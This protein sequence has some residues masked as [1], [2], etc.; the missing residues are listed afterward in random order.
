MEAELSALA[1]AGGTA[2][3]QAVGTEAWT[4]M[5]DRVA[6]WFRREGGDEELTAMLLEMSRDDLLPDGHEAQFTAVWGETLRRLLAKNPA[7]AAELRR[8]VV[9]FAPTVSGS[10][11]VVTC[12]NGH[13]SDSA[14]WCDICGV[15]MGH[16]VAPPVPDT[17]SPVHNTVS[18]GAQSTVIQT[19]TIDSLT[20]N[21]PSAAPPGDHVN[22]S[23]GTFHA[24]V[25]GVQNNYGTPP[26]QASADGW[27]RIGELRRLAPGAHPTR[28]FGDEPD[29]PPY[30][31]RDSD[32][33]LD[34]L[35][36][37]GLREGGLVLVTG[38]PL[39]GKT[40]TAW[41][42]LARTAAD[43]T[44]VHHAHAGTDLRDLPAL[45]HGHD[46]AHAYVVWLDD[47]EGH[48]GEQ[49]LTAGVL[50]S[51]TREGALVLATMRDAAYDTHRFGDHPSAPVLRRAHTVE[52]ARDWSAAELAR[53]AAADDPR[54]L[55]AARRRGA[56][57]VTEFLAVGPELWAE[58]RR[59]RRPA[60]HPQ[61]HLLVRAAIDL[62]RCGIDRDVPVSL[63]RETQKQYGEYGT[64][65]F[66]EALDWATALRHGVTGLLVPGE[67]G[68][69]GEPEEPGE[70]AKKGEA[71]YRAYGSLVADAARSTEIPPVPDAVWATAVL[72]AD[73]HGLGAAE[74]VAACRAVAIPRATAGDVAAYAMLGGLAQF[75]GD[76]AAAERW[77]RKAADGGHGRARAVL[78]QL[79]ADRGATAEAIRCL[80]A[81]AEEGCTDVYATLGRLHQERA[82]HWLAKAE[83]E[84][85]VG[86]ESP[87][88]V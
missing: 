52:L 78:G 9:E 70:S 4:A 81:A 20:V 87:A 69:P 84:G 27:P 44:R 3:V 86:G 25:I 13:L 88:G 73:R 19:G 57:G 65:E 6:R 32:E 1:A 31:P 64:T 45:L 68:E 76:M 54:L 29:L 60:A 38:E 79:L 59:A 12:R 63:L 33:E 62:A 72:G 51:L 47:L 10:G 77:Y 7:A 75:E 37:R 55:D 26:A 14:D 39:S 58:W 2:I 50:D 48:L 8:I 74:V 30:V 21:E 71:T 5:R 42:A 35:V 22:F 34:P 18:G 43:G 82:R 56:L 16:L 11:R 83:G 66:E 24:P 17:P 23:K 28:R 15:R 85:R 67:P 49:G 36:A 61:G 46:A 80:E 41:A 40:M 53:L